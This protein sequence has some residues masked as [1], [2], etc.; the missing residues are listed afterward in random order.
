M[1]LI[2][3]SQNAS[4]LP[5]LDCD[6]INGNEVMQQSS[7]QEPYYHFIDYYIIAQII[8]QDYL[9]QHNT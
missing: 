8:T 5:P 4:P 2:L 6:V 9:K 7:S 3:S 1:A